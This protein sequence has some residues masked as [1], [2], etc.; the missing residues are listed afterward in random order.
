MK[1]IKNEVVWIII[2]TISSERY[3][4]TITSGVYS[5]LDKAVTA[6][7]EL[8]NK[9]CLEEITNQELTKLEDKV[10]SDGLNIT[11]YIRY[12]SKYDDYYFETITVNVDTI[13]DI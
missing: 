2:V 11:R 9:I 7:K 10:E 12:K 8:D 1:Q 13:N 5:N 6:V 4:H 3:S